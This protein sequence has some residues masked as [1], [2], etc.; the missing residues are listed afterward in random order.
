M[1][2]GFAG[3]VRFWPGH[4]SPLAW[5]LGAA[6]GAIVMAVIEISINGRYMLANR[7]EAKRRRRREAQQT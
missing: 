7:A 4:G 5:L 1:F 3:V 2:L 6:A